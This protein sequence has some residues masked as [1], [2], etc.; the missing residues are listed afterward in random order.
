MGSDHT[1]RMWPEL[2]E[3][4]VEQRRHLRRVP[5]EILNRIADMGPADVSQVVRREELEL[6]LRRL[7]APSLEAH[8][9]QLDRI[10]DAER[11]IELQTFLNGQPR[12]PA[13]NLNLGDLFVEASARVRDAPPD[14]DLARDEGRVLARA[15]WLLIAA[16]VLA[17]D[18]TDPRLKLA[19]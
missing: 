16:D 18:Y 11:A 6:E 15:V 8:A 2:D 4:R 10:D 13:M 17:G 1:P 19:E 12:K 7:V 3:L 5:T 14:P 9:E